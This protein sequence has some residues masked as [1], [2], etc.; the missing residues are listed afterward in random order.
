MKNILN[1]KI[2][3]IIFFLI[4]VFPSPHASLPNFIVL[5]VMVLQDLFMVDKNLPS[6]DFYISILVI[7]SVLLF[8]SKKN[9]IFLISII[10]QFFY[11]IFI[12][13]IENIKYWYFTIPYFLFI[14][15]S[16]FLIFNHF[17]K[18]KKIIY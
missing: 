9:I 3:T 5:V 11:L 12:F 6:L 18:R 8:F 2:I 14:I 17:G 1:V 13:K 15:F 4:I 7:I 10:I 16:L